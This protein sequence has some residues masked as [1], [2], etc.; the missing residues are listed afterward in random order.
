MKLTTFETTHG[1]RHIGALLPGG[2]E[3]VDFTVADARPWFRSML[4]LI[5][6][7]EAALAAAR[8]LVATPPNRVAVSAVKVLAPV[9][10]PR[11]MRDCLSFEM[12]V[13][14]ARANRYLF[15]MGTERVDPAK[16]DIPKV[17][18]ELPV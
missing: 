14:Q 6:G 10:E 7:G 2:T 13:R 5:D 1:A 4:D 15:G 12:H 9:P 16:V 18:Y 8:A 17:W 3:I 11:Q